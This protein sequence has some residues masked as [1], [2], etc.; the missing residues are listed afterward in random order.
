MAFTYRAGMQVATG[1]DMELRDICGSGAACERTCPVMK[2]GRV[3]PTVT[4]FMDEIAACG[5]DPATVGA[6]PV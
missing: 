5:I 6:V 1:A 3:C 4:E 2:L